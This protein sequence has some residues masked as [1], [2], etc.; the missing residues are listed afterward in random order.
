MKRSFI[1]L[2][3]YN[4]S[5][6]LSTIKLFW[7]TY[8][9][10]YGLTLA[11]W[12][13]FLDAHPADKTIPYLIDYDIYI[14][15]KELLVGYGEISF[16]GEDTTIS[17]INFELDTRTV[18]GTE[19]SD[20]HVGMKV[21]L[22]SKTEGILFHGKI[23]RIGTITGFTKHLGVMC[24]NITINGVVGELEPISSFFILLEEKVC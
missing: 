15:L 8:H 2:E 23:G 19:L 3:S 21:F 17:D 7:E 10:E 5:Y 12:K 16:Y 14:L 13:E 20:S 1:T 6:R 4:S 18:S 24:V 11:Y 9:P 22:P